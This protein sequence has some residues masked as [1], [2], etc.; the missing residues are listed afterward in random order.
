MFGAFIVTILVC[1]LIDGLVL[2]KK[3]NC[4]EKDNEKNDSK[5]AMTSLP[6]Y[7]EKEEPAADNAVVY[8]GADRAYTNGGFEHN[9]KLPID[10]E[11]FC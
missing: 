11:R 6:A 8:N 3:R 4:A 10:G 1:T 7:T 2:K 9:E 5:Y